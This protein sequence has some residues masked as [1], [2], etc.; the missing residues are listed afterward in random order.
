[1][2]NS[3]Q[4]KSTGT[5]VFSVLLSLLC[6]GAFLRIYN[7]WI[8]S[9]WVDEYVTWWVVS[10]STW[11]DV[12][13]RAIKT[14]GQ[15]PF[16]FC[17]VRLVTDVL[18]TG[19][20]QLRLP[21]VIF[22][23]TTLVIAYQ[24][25]SRL[26]HDRYVA[27]VSVAVFS[28]SERLISLSQNARPYALALCLTMLSFLF[29]LEVLRTKSAG[30]VIGYV[31]T[32]TLL[33]YSHFL[34]GFV[35]IVQL[36]VLAFR[37]GWREL[38]S[39]TWTPSFV[40]IAVL[41]LPLFGQI[42]SLYERRQSLDWLHYS[43]ESD[44]WPQ[45]SAVARGFSDPWALLLTVVTLLAL[46]I[47]PFNSLD[48]NTKAGLRLLISWLAIPVVSL[49]LIAALLG[50]SFLEIRYI[51]FVYP[52]A[53]YLLAWLLLN[54]RPTDWRRWLPSG[55]F[56]LTTFTIAL[57]PNLFR[58]AAFSQWSNWGWDEAGR[59]LAA[60]AQPKDAVIFYTGLIE[61]DL[62]ARAPDDPFLLS[63]V[64]WPIAAHL[65][66]NHGFSLVSLPYHLSEQ[67]E[68]Y[69]KSV[70]KRAA[71]HD[72]VWVIGEDKLVNYFSK[73]MISEFGFG[74]VRQYSTNGKIQVASLKK[75]ASKENPG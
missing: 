37:A 44:I 9:L 26:F 66:A 65:P 25:G 46:G 8:P 68:A 51:V 36:T 20:F 59:I 21:S 22:G 39:R 35:V 12:A 34:F 1:M 18:G 54:L 53:F 3:V 24:L 55:V 17:V 62:F 5:S 31:I 38:L 50:V 15:S 10:G 23:I 16:Y 7:F 69:L 45:A 40:A 61:A 72:Q 49:W 27:L 6:L 28:V 64:S 60:N 14:Q 75:T 42:F 41:C 11:T 13:D 30:H 58:T 74:L 29:F 43:G 57:M 19:P 48:S 71:N 47:K 4:A 52:A 32:T 70:E 73:K 63:Y 67:T 56:V 2:A 33:I